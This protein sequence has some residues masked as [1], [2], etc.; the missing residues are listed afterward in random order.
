VAIAP[1]PV[2]VSVVAP[3]PEWW[4][5][6]AA[7]GP[8]AVLI[9]ALA[10]AV[11]GLMTLHERRKADAGSLAQK[12]EAD[13]RSE[14]W[15]RAQWALDASLSGDAIRRRMGLRIMAVLARSELAGTEETRIIEVVWQSL[16]EA[17]R[18]PGAARFKQPAAA[19]PDERDVQV[20]AAQLRLITDAKLGRR[21]PPW[22]R[23][24]ASEEPDD[25]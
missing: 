19:E 15:S 21:T 9:A 13:M 3:P 18:A 10:A 20:A 4:Q 6:V 11:D 16:P 22:V 14:W 5:I 12:A 7:L 17:G 23:D 1:V 25:A 24:L 2:P 8:F